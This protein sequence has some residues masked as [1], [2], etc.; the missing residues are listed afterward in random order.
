[1]RVV[2][3][4]VKSA[5]VKLNGKMADAI[6]KGLLVFVGIEKGDGQKDIDYIASKVSGL[7]I[8]EDDAG[9][10]N[11]DIK[12]VNGSA[13]IISQFTLAGSVIKGKRPSFSKA[14]LPEKAF[15]IYKNLIEKIKTEEIDV[16]EGV[17]QADMEVELVNNG[18]VTILLDSNRTF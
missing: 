16:H 4:R 8:F 10:M 1:M 17:F 13:L 18:P 11:L 9:K 6:D 14:E 2:V 15:L 5:C 3:Q 12:S 7:R